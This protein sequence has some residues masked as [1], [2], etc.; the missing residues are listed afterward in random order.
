MMT[1]TVHQVRCYCCL[2]ALSLAIVH[3]RMAAV[4]RAQVMFHIKYRVLCTVHEFKL[5]NKLKIGTDINGTRLDNQLNM[6]IDI[7]EKRLDSD[8]K[9]RI[10]INGTRLYNQVNMG[11]DVN[12][13]TGQSAEERNRY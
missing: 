9:I 5:G 12:A 10:A 3:D 6:E 8:L 11:I 4:L 2:E 7:N 13:T 1:L